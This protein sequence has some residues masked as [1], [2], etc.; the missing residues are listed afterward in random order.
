MMRFFMLSCKEATFLMAKKEEG[1]LTFFERMKLSF[2]TSMCRFCRLFE[3]QTKQIRE[4]S[5]H[6]HAEEGLSD[7]AKRRMQRLIDSRHP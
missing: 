1:K 6:I 5:R 2:H 3:K 4:E 7:A